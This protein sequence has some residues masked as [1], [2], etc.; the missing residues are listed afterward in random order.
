MALVQDPDT[1]E[2]TAMPA[3]AMKAVP[4]ARV[5]SLAGIVSFVSRLPAGVPERE[6]A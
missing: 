5:M 2:S 1:A 6:D 4:R 3:A